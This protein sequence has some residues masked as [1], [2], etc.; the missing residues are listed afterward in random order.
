MEIIPIAFF[1]SPF[2][3][4]FG[5]PRQ[6]GIVDDVEGEIIFEPFIN[7]SDYVRGLERYDYIWL[8]WGFSGNSSTH[9]SP[10]VRPP[11]LGGNKRVGV[12]STRSP[13][14]PNPIGLSS[15]RLKEIYVNSAKRLCLKVTGADLM[16]GTPIYDIK[17]YLEYTDSH[18]NVRSG[19]P[20]ENQW[21]QLK[22]VF[23]EHAQ[24]VLSTQEQQ[25]I[26]KILEQ[27]PR[28]HY[29]ADGEKVYGMRY[30]EK[31]IHFKV[32][33]ETCIVL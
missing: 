11:I 15:V 10:T 5:I 19:L 16:N 9:V 4:K 18:V 21:K 29:Q 6:S 12:F 33:H 25:M 7:Q 32:N 23:S 8:L 31:D 26:A 20:D 2:I 1:R 24:T 27:D 28:P 3:T 13:Y 14:R 17:P 30:D 22:V